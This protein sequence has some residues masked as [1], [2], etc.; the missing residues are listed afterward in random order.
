MKT[1]RQI[2]LELHEIHRN[3]HR[4]ESDLDCP[5]CEARQNLQQHTLAFLHEEALASIV[6]KHQELW[7][8]LGARIAN[9]LG[10]HRLPGEL[11]SIILKYW[12]EP[13]PMEPDDCPED[14]FYHPMVT[15]LFQ[16]QKK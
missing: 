14:Y 9:G 6:Q 7:K 16:T 15:Y 2:V 1:R 12:I 3:E 13:P 10:A 5:M 4:E 8:N 11:A